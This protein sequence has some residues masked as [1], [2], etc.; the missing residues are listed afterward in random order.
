MAKLRHIALSVPDPEAAAQF[1]E[2]A[3]GMRRAGQAMRGIYMTDGVMNVALLDFKNEPIAGQE[4]RPNGPGVLHFGMWVEDLD[5][6]AERIKQAGGA[7]VTGR[8]ETSPHVY[9]EVK[10]KT[11]EGIVFDITESGW[12]GAVKEVVPAKASADEAT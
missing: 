12:K 10:Y 2:K 3:F 1:F 8:K 9:Y 5:A 11:P 7:Y 4:G 6:A